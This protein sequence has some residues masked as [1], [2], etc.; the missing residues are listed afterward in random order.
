MQ[1]IRFDSRFSN[2]S[3]DIQTIK[4]G[5]TIRLLDI[6]RRLY[7]TLEQLLVKKSNYPNQSRASWKSQG[8]STFA[9]KKSV[10]LA[11]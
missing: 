4:H 6:P 10:V 5:T 3:P 8:K 7:L 1:E 11:N 2:V 9:H